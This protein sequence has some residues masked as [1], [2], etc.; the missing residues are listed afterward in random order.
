MT[1]ILKE[2]EKFNENLRECL[3]VLKEV[4]DIQDSTLKVGYELVEKLT[5]KE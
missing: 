2:M 1:E 4:R 5:P 3:R